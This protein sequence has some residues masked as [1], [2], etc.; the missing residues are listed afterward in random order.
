MPTKLLW[1]WYR[2]SGWLGVLVVLAAF[3]NWPHRW[4]KGGQF[5]SFGFPFDV[6][7]YAAGHWLFSA[8]ALAIDVVF[9]TAILGVIPVVV[10]IRRSGRVKLPTTEMSPS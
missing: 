10:S 6:A 7:T 8:A 1:S 4:G 5:I 9:W 2:F 3:A